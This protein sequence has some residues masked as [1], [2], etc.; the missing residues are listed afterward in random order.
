MA[1]SYAKCKGTYLEIGIDDPVYSANGAVYNVSVDI[2]LR[3]YNISWGGGGYNFTVSL[4][5]QSTTVSGISLSTTSG[6]QVA[7]KI[8][9]AS[10]TDVNPGTYT[11]SVVLNTNGSMYYSS[12]E[13]NGASHSRSLS[14]ATLATACTAPTSISVNRS[15]ATPGNITISWSGAKAGTLNAITKYRIY[16]AIGSSPTTNSSYQDSSDTTA[17]SGSITF[18]ASSRGSTYYFKIATIGTVNGY[19]SGLSSTEATCIINQ[20]PNAPALNK[21]SQV[22]T[23]GTS[24]FSITATAGAAN[25]GFT[26]QTVYYNNAD[27]HTGQIAVTSGSAFNIGGSNQKVMPAQGNSSTY[28]FW[29]YD[30]AEYSSATSIT[31]TRNT[32]PSASVDFTP[33]SY[34]AQGRAATTYEYVSSLTVSVNSNK[35][36]IEVQLLYGNSSSPTTVINLPNKTVTTGTSS[37]LGLYNINNLL[38]DY[39]TGARLYFGLRVRAV[40]NYENGEWTN[41]TVYSIAAAPTT[42]TT[43][44]SFYNSAEPSAQIVSGYCWNQICIKYLEDTSMTSRTVSAKAGT[45]TITA[46][47]TSEST[48]GNYRYLNVTLPS[49]ITGNTVI[50]ITVTLSDGNI[51]KSFTASRTELPTPSLGALGMSLSTINM[52]TTTSNINLTCTAPCA[53]NS[54]GVIDQTGTYKITSMAVDV[55]SDS[56]GANSRPVTINTI[57][58]TTEGNTLTIPITKTNFTS[59]GDFGKTTYNGTSTGYVR[60][61]F[62]NIYQRTFVAGYK[63]Y[64][65]DYNADPS[66]VSIAMRYGTG[67]ASLS[68]IQESL[69]VKA[70]VTY[71]AYSNSTLTFKLYYQI[72]SGSWTL[73]SST[74]STVG[75]QSSGYSSNKTLTT[76]T[77]TIPEVSTTDSW[78]WKVIL[79]NSVTSSAPESSTVTVAALKHIAPVVNLTNVE[80]IET[81]NHETRTGINFKPTLTTTSN[82]SNATSSII[83]YYIV[84]GGDDTVI[85]ASF[86]D[87]DLSSSSWTGVADTSSDKANWTQKTVRIKCV[88]T[89]TGDTTTTKTGYSNQFTIYLDSP[90]IAYRKNRLGINT[91]NPNTDAVVDIYSQSGGLQ[92]INLHNVSSG[93]IQIDLLNST[94]DIV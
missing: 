48:S 83:A 93:M 37:S 33:T 13:M 11:I 75:N 4:A 47:K 39:Y 35:P 18:N 77:F 34:L 21:S 66:I 92:Y 6:S 60:V 52:Y 50:T 3:H 32:T 61:V 38:K 5:G 56:S 40:D 44:D 26:G 64:T 54:S 15:P 28:Y 70:Y 58:Q 88:T 82:I 49:D 84:N 89:A 9:T 30:G 24:T 36:T 25:I 41:S 31:I 22:V 7:N 51:S 71:K 14:L 20:L 69:S 80:G 19:D 67:T 23:S 79:T 63:S 8:G 87:A 74:T 27:S 10:F 45:T 59:F 73:A 72:G 1:I 81:P 43:W 17:T 2:Y 29:T 76:N 91:A 78:K 68:K 53:F 94:I 46:T 62:T 86:T 90:T 16:Y 85:S 12:I 57:S 65:L 55:A 42:T